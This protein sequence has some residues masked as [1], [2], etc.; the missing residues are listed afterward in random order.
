MQQATSQGLDVLLVSD[1]RANW[2]FIDALIDTEVD[3]LS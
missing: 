3:Q 1:T 2:H